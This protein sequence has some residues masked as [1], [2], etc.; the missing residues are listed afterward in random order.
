MRVGN[1]AGLVR[2]LPPILQ[3]HCILYFISNE[4]ALNSLIRICGV[5]FLCCLFHA[6]QEDRDLRLLKCVKVPFS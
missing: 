5:I 3:H 2:L 4:Y 1:G 6:F